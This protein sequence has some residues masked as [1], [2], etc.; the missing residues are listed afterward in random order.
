MRKLISALA[1]FAFA[2][3]LFGETPFAGT[4]KLDS[5]K[6]K[7]TAGQPPKDVTIVIEE[8]GDNL[9]VTGTGT[10]SD[11][12]PLSVK[13]T[14]PTNGGEAKIESGPWD[15]ITSKRINANERE[16]HYSKNGKEVSTRRIVVAKNGKTMRSTVKGMNPTGDTVAGTDV[17]QKQ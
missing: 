14:V 5:A 2:G 8:Q 1:L 17:F 7:Y 6:T 10:N 13:Y 9:L 16:N 12:S 11:G 4:W 3:A 15:S